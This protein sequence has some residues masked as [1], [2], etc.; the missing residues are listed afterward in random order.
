MWNN[1]NNNNNNN[2][3][4]RVHNKP[5]FFFA[6]IIVIP[7]YKTLDDLRFD[8]RYTSSYELIASKIRQTNF[9]EWIELRNSLPSNLKSASKSANL[10]LNPSFSFESG[11][12][13]IKQNKRSSSKKSVFL[14]M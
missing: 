2:K 3:D 4:V 11:V 14:V 7:A 5:F 8:L 1:N 12:F 13:D 10:D 6:R 9:L